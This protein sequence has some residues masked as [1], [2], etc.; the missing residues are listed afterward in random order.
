MSVDVAHALERAREL[1]FRPQLLWPVIAGE[2]VTP[3][4]LYRDYIAVLAAIPPLATFL[5]A[6][7]LGYDREFGVI[8][9]VEMVQ[10]LA[11]MLVSYLLLLVAVFGTALAIEALAAN[12]GG[13]RDRLLSLKLA[14]YSSTA[15]CLGAAAVVVPGVGGL[16]HLAAVGYGFYLAYLGVQVLLGMPKEKALPFTALCALVSVV[17]NMA[18]VSLAAKLTGS[19]VPLAGYGL[20]I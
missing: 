1:L 13:R 7:V 14:G 10:G 18:V 20:L 8:L 9:R 17:L 19:P 3:E 4:A 2:Q 5:K 11:A 16:I 6:C 12:F 15:A